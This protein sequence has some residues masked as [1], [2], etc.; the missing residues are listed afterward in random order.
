M[1]NRAIQRLCQS[2]RNKFN[3]EDLITITKINE[4]ILKLNPTSK[5]IGRSLY[6]CKNIECIKNLIKK[7]RIRSALKFNNQAEIERIEKE[8]SDLFK[9]DN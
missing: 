7:K 3:R 4:N 2:C 6:V 9:K 5:E 1:E 8:L